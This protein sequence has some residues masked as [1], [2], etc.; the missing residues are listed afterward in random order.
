MID[1]E[2][3]S[4]SFKRNNA[5]QILYAI[6]GLIHR[7][8]GGC[9]ILLKPEIIHTQFIQIWGKNSR[10]TCCSNALHSL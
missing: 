1:F 8:V 9:T 2:D 10:S 5:L 3:P 6:N 4:F 7:G